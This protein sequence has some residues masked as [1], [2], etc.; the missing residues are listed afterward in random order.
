MLTGSSARAA[1][2][3][4][5]RY[6]ELCAFMGK[7]ARCPQ[8]MRR[9]PSPSTAAEGSLYKWADVQR[10]RRNGTN[11]KATSRPMV[12]HEASRLEMLPG[13]H[14][15]LR[16]KPRGRSSMAAAEWRAQ[17]QLAQRP[18]PGSVALC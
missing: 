12:Q 1:K 2:T 10:M 15:G 11:V 4:E 5:R 13:W 6:A 3:W 16:A 9:N 8:D 14:W 18:R 7:H 17:L